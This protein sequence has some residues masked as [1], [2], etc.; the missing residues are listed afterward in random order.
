M[1]ISCNGGNDGEITTI[2]TNS[3]GPC[4]YVWKTYS[5]PSTTSTL[6]NTGNSLTDGTA[7]NYIVIVTDSLGHSDADTVNLRQPGPLMAGID[8][9]V[10]GGGT[11]ISEFGAQD[12]AMTSDISGGVTPYTYLW[13]PGAHTAYNYLDVAAGQYTLTV[14]DA[15]G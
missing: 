15:A 3:T 9:R 6:S 1:N 13:Q 11:N 4:S 2:V 7:G 8:P 5:Y 10:Y 12:G 14:T